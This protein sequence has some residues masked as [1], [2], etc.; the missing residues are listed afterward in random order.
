MQD[1]RALL[2]TNYGQQD[3]GEFFKNFDNLIPFHQ[4]KLEHL[5]EQK[6]ALLQQMFV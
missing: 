6:K 1:D 4:L 3:I 2:Y 5:Q